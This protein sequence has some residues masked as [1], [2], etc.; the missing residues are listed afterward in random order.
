MAKAVAAAAGG[1]GR[2]AYESDGFACEP[3]E[4]GGGDTTRGEASVR[5]RYGAI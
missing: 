2:A 4:A 5:F 1:R 3:S